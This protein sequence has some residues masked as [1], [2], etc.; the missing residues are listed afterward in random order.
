MDIGPSNSKSCRAQ[1]DIGP[2]TTESLDEVSSTLDLV[3]RKALSNSTLYWT[4][5]SRRPCRTQLDIGPVAAEGL[6][7]LNSTLDLVQRKALSNS[8]LDCNRPAHLIYS[9][10]F[11]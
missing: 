8:A 11:A 10:V 6:V 9:V 7:E 3:Q 2:G 1:L 5:C 4:R